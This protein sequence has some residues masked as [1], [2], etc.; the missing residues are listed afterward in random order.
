MDPPE[1]LVPLILVDRMSL[2]VQEVKYPPMLLIPSEL[3]V[4]NQQL[5]ALLNQE[6]ILEANRDIEK[7]PDGFVAVATVDQPGVKA[8]QHWVV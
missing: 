2:L 3:R 4:R 5:F 8:I 1:L 7:E 6:H